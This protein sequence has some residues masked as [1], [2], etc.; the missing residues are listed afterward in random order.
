M[1]IKKMIDTIE[2]Q[3]MDTESF[4]S[5]LHN[6]IIHFYKEKSVEGYV[7]VLRDMLSLAVHLKFD[8]VLKH[9]GTAPVVAPDATMQFQEMFKCLATRSTHK[10]WFLDLFALFL[11]LGT[12]LQFDASMIEET[13]FKEKGM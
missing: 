7:K 6:K 13:F 4:I 2:S 5:S 9:F 8:L 12:V 10:N 1:N 3:E 11:G